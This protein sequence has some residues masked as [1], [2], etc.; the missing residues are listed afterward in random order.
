VQAGPA[1]DAYPEW[2]VRH[3]PPG[4]HHG[5]SDGTSCPHEAA[6]P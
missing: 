6:S 1:T 4:S 2:P 3:L 5:S